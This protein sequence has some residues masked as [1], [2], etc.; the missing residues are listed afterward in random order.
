MSSVITRPVF[1]VVMIAIWS[2]VFPLIAG[3]YN[4]ISLNTVDSAASTSERFDRVFPKG[5]HANSEDA[6]ESLTAVV[7]HGGTAAAIVA[8]SAYKIGDDS[9]DL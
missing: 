7:A 4:S 9:G 5:T 1:W 8:T 6:W 2:L 3:A